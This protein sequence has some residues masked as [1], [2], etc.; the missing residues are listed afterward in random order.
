MHFVIG[1]SI[2]NNSNQLKTLFKG[3]DIDK[4][5]CLEENELMSNFV[6]CFLSNVFCFVFLK[7]T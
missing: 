3:G 6:G 2:F 4:K 7:Y 1:P 5:C